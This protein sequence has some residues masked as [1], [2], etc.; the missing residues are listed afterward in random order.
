MLTGRQEVVLR[1]VVE[2]YVDSGDPV[3]SQAIAARGDV[4]FSSS[5][6]RNEFA[7][8]EAHGFLEQPHTSAGRVPTESGMRYFVDTLLSDASRSLDS[9]PAF[10]LSPVKREVEAV[11]R[12]TTETL[13][14]ATELLA[15][16]SA[17]PLG[18]EEILRTELILLGP[19][20]LTVVLITS[21]GN[22]SRRVFD[23]AGEIDAGLV[24]WANGFLNETLRGVPLGA[25]TIRSRLSEPSLAPVERDFVGAIASVFLEPPA[26][27]DTLFI[28]GASHLV[29][30]DRFRSMPGLDRLMNA[31]EERVAVLQM[32]RSSLGERDVYLRIGSEN[33]VPE[34]AGASVVG[35]NYGTPLRNLGAVS[36]IGPVR[37]NYPHAISSVRYAAARLSD[38]V[39]DVYA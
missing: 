19:S 3:G 16:V 25:R 26:G 17:P 15:L 35:A 20:K 30:A 34:L 1:L 29:S 37:M 12:E 7:V 13:A 23:F 4:D 31:L 10:E 22:V 27:A 18:T 9:A 6:I 38:F 2:G 24:E 11:M 28:G 14:D 5:T 33:E 36:V 32:V 21:A 39:A 8:L